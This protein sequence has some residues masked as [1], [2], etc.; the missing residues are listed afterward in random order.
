MYSPVHVGYNYSYS[1]MYRVDVG[2]GNDEVAPASPL[3]VSGHRSQPACYRMVNGSGRLPGDAQRYKWMLANLKLLLPSSTLFYL[4][5][6]CACGNY[7]N[8]LS[9]VR[10]EIHVLLYK[11]T[12]LLHSKHVAS[13]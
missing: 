3:R 8:C 6:M 1:D 13:S 4:F 9:L 7:F 2:L 5:C 10:P 12:V 11:V